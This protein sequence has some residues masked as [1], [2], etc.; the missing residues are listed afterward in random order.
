MQGTANVEGFHRHESGISFELFKMANR[1]SRDRYEHNFGEYELLGL[2]AH[3]SKAELHEED[4]VRAVEEEGGV[5][6]KR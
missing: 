2:V 6:G 3:R 1:P 4:H 5:H